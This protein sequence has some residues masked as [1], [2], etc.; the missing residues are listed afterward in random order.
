[1]FMSKDGK[2]ERLREILKDITGDD[3]PGPAEKKGGAVS[4]KIK[5]GSNNT[6]ISGDGNRVGSR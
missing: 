2:K 1:M 5:G 4:Q 3:R 6:Q